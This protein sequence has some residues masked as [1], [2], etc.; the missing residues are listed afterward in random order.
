MPSLP[1]AAGSRFGASLALPTPRLGSDGAALAADAGLV[2]Q[3]AAGAPAENVKGAVYRFAVADLTAPGQPAA[4]KRAIVG[5]GG[6]FGATLAF[7]A[8]APAEAQAL[9]VAAPGDN[10]VRIYPASGGDPREVRASSMVSGLGTSLARLP[11]ADGDV[12]IAGAP[13]LAASGAA[14]AAY[15]VRGATMVALPS[16][17]LDV[18]GA[19]AAAALGGARP[20]DAFGAGVVV[21]DFDQDGWADLAVAASAA[22]SILVYRGP[23]P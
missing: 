15:L 10:A 9:V 4:P 23:L 17:Q 1:G 22:R 19:P 20:G 14:G 11:R 8:V 7:A 3:V 13:S 12:V 6:G 21:G 18:A 16:L 5:L 2:G